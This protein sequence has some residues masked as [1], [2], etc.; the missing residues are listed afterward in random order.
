MNSKSNYKKETW[1]L[2]KF[3]ATEGAEKGMSI[4][5]K[6]PVWKDADPQVVINSM[7]GEN[8][9]ALFDMEAFQ[10][11]VMADDA[12]CGVDNVSIASPE[13]RTILKEETDKLFWADKIWTN[14]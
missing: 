11:V 13:I 12:V 7:L 6:V 10:R 9:A 5:G 4:A 3:I 14:I 2:I 8:A 1:E